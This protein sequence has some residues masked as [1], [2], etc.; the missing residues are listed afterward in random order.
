MQQNY[1]TDI[2]YPYY[3]IPYGAVQTVIIDTIP[4][5]DVDVVLS[6]YLPLLNGLTFNFID[7]CPLPKG[8]K[9]RSV[10][11]TLQDDTA[12]KFDIPFNSSDTINYTSLLTQLDDPNIKNWVINGEKIFSY[13]LP[14]LLTKVP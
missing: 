3:N 12:Y 4:N 8:L 10:T 6:T 14:L 7:V 5:Q 9:P 11:I 13:K 1:T 2:G